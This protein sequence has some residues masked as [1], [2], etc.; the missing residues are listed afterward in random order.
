LTEQCIGRRLGDRELLADEIAAW[1]TDR[2]DRKATI[3]WR[4]T[5][6]SARDKLKK[7]YPIKD[8]E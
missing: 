7:L 8:I 2:N 4:F 3:D 1:E 6:P 5:I